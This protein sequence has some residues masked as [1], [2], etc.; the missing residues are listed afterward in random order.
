MADHN[1]YL[2]YKRDTRHLLY[3]MTHAYNRILKSSSSLSISG[4]TPITPN[5]TGQ[6][7][8][9]ALVPTSKLIAEHLKT[10]PS[11]IYHLF[12]SV[13]E[14]RSASHAIFKQI[15]ANKPDP[16]IEKSNVSHK[17]FIDAL[18]G[19]FKALGGD[20]WASKQKSEAPSLDQK[21]IEEV[22]FANQ[23]SVLGLSE[24]DE[25]EDDQ[26]ANGGEGGS[27]H[28]GSVQKARPRKKPSG[29]GKKGK[30]GK[31]A[32]G[33]PK[34][35]VKE[36]SLDEVP[37]ESYRI[38]EDEDGV[39]TDYLMAVYAFI[40]EAMDYRQCVQEFWRE[41]AYADLN[42]AVAGTLSNMAIAMVKQVE[43]SIFV[44]FPGHDSYETIMNTI[45]RGDPDK[46]QGMFHLD[47]HR[48]NP[49]LGMRPQKVKSIDVDIKEQFLIHAYRDLLDFVTDFQKN[50]SGKP[51]K[52]MLAEI[53]DWDP[54]FNLRTAT[55][56]QRIRWRRSYTINWLYDLV[57]V[58]SSIVVQR[59]K[60]K[61][62]DIALE[63]VDWSISGPW[64]EHRRL[65]GLNE[66]AGEVTSLAMQKP[67]TN[68]RPKILPHL[69]FQMQ[70]I[71]D[72]LTVSRGWTVNPLEGH[73]LTPP[74]KGFRPRRDVDLFLDRKAERGVGH[75][76]CHG[77]DGLTQFFEKDAMLHG[78]PDR[79]T[80]HT[81]MLRELR[82]DFVDWL[83]VSKYQS[84]L[85]GIPPS[86][87]T[88]TNSNGLWE[89]SPFLNGVG[90]VEALELAYGLNF[91][92]WERM[93]EPMCL[94]HLHNMLVQTGYL[95][96]PVGL[97]QT[98]EMLFPQ[99]FFADAKAPESNFG[100]A[101]AK[102]AQG[103]NTRRVASQRRRV[104][105]A[106][107]RSTTGIHGVLE[108]NAN[109]FYRQKSRLRIYREAGWLV[110][111]IP[112]AD[113]SMDSFLGS[114]RMSQAE[115]ETDSGTGKK[116]T[117]D[118]EE[119][120]IPEEFWPEIPEGY[121]TGPRP[122]SKIPA[123]GYNGPDLLRFLKYDIHN[124]IAGEIAPLSSV[125][126]VWVTANMM[127]KFT[128]FEDELK[129]LRNP[130]WVRAYEQDASMMRQK[131]AS[132]TGL[133]LSQQDD[134]CM[135]VLAEIFE[136]GREGI[137]NFIY[138]NDL[139]SMEKV[140]EKTSSVSVD[141]LGG[142]GPSGCTV[143]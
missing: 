80:E 30:R 141:P 51:T 59:N 138:W 108:M 42:S 98:L 112:D 26:A 104:G 99:S 53:R 74:G 15:V 133:I 72:S 113:A 16:E 69:V 120:P 139:D 11:V 76:Y 24:S 89:Y 34:P 83:G 10:I 129:R 60:L 62:Q 121:T 50:R 106:A 8:V 114:L 122:A 36:P 107:S 95:S 48:A 81:Y 132:L 63:T 27:A 75:G 66:F 65:F 116:T 134:E 41:V 85:A 100:E 39:I 35:T 37:L 94:I 125:N 1:S 105:L 135:R 90:L 61:G 56:E 127:R 33:K 111:R 21:E 14:A 143:M 97:Y 44:D 52:A 32:K 23:F 86:R 45:T 29:K 87:F 5:T 3:W 25:E 71:V 101:Y 58:F 77:V 130:L 47:L 68:I 119:S 22:I 67:G 79:H 109:R 40:K 124:D 46:A 142:A 136:S 78:D 2:A 115:E 93:P 96:K 84:S 43:L 70:C 140:I 12:Q 92:I 64:D 126:Y 49:S 28:P 73:I 131:R 54:N 4:D 118:T 91:L 7:T 110:D 31:K 38:I 55:K 57:N 18:T 19:A 88:S 123:E 117:E 20:E 137:I 9:S 102:I 17:C 103:T 82:D 6:I 13:I 128:L